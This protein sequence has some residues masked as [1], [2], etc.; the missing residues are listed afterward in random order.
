MILPPIGL[1]GSE[2][3]LPSLKKMKSEDPSEMQ[4]EMQLISGPFLS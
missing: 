4:N 3:N 1:S 2:R